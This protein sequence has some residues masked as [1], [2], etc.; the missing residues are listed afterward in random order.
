VALQRV[1]APIACGPS[2]P[3]RALREAAAPFEGRHLHDVLEVETEARL[4]DV[5]EGDWLVPLGGP[6]D[7][8]IVEAL[9]PLGID[10]LFRWAFFDSV[11]DKEGGLQRLRVRG[12][13]RAAAGRRAGLRDRFEAWKAATPAC[14]AIARRCSAS[15]SRAQRYA[16]REWRLYPVL[17]CSSC[18]K[19]ELRALDQGSA[20]ARTRAAGR[21]WCRC[22]RSAPHRSGTACRRCC[23][24]APAPRCSG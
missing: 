8:F 12:R 2:L 21:R 23:S 4:V 16:E 20:S 7:R 18:R 19:P 1:R 14:S 22:R 17:P 3:H 11:L 9:E 13:G 5:A 10:S 6:H 15:S 24:T